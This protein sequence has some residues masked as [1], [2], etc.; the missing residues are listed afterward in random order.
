MTAPSSS[1][2][3]RPRVAVLGCASATGVIGPRRRQSEYGSTG[4]IPLARRDAQSN[5]TVAPYVAPPIAARRRD[6]PA[7]PPADRWSI[8]AGFLFYPLI[9]G[10]V[11]SV[12]DTG[13]RVSRPSW[14]S[15]LRPRDPRR[16]RVPSEPAEHVRSPAQRSCSRRARLFLAVL[17]A[18]VN[19]DGAFSAF[20]SSRRSS[21]PRAVGAVWKFLY[22][23]SFGIVADGAI[24]PRARHA[25]VRAARGSPTWP[26][27][28]SWPPSCGGSPASAWSSTWRRSETLPREYYEHA[29]PRG[30]RP[31]PAVPPD[32]LAAAVAADVRAGAADHARHAAHLRHGVDHDRGRSSHATETVATDVYATAFRFLEVGYAQ[33]MAMILLV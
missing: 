27:G 1:T 21:W 18:D 32:H 9:Y 33:A 24:G 7:V 13:L 19:A 11:L 26:C 31:L 20:V 6:R 23:P 8:L 4:Q 25:D 5:P 14:A 28:R 12:H 3:R 2:S 22:A 17:V 15:P 30:R 29:G 10:L 16:R